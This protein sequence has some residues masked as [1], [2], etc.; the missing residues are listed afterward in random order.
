MLFIILTQVDPCYFELK[1]KKSPAQKK[2]M[3]TKDTETGLKT[4]ENNSKSDIIYSIL[5]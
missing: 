4:G 1:A 5:V 3:K 2:I